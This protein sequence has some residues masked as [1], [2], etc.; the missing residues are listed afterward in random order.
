MVKSFTK[1][2]FGFIKELISQTFHLTG[3]LGI[4]RIGEVRMENEKDRQNDMYS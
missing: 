4:T 1:A 2:A 3:E